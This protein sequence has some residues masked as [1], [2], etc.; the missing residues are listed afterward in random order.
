MLCSSKFIML[1][2]IFGK[3]IEFF[4]DYKIIYSVSLY[5]VGK[6]AYNR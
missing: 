6:V 3:L 1:K 4:M 5:G 2:K